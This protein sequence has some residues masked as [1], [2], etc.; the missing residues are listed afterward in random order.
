MEIPG[1]PSIDSKAGTIIGG[2]LTLFNVGTTLFLMLSGVSRISLLETAFYVFLW[3]CVLFFLA[4]AI[5]SS[6][7]SLN[8]YVPAAVIA[9]ILFAINTWTTITCG[10]VTL[11]LWFNI[12]FTLDKY[13]P[14]Y[15]N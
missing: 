7:C 11:E 9:I 6:G 12:V 15:C 13:N 3:S 2:V 10:K 8:L 14:L 1:V 5:F 4:A